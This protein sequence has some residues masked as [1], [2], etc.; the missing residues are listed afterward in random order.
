[1]MGKREVAEVAEKIGAMRAASAL[2]AEIEAK[3]GMGRRIN[4]VGKDGAPTGRTI[5]HGEVLRAAGQIAEYELAV[6][7]GKRPAQVV[8]DVCHTIVEVPSTGPTPK[9]HRACARRIRNARHRS[10]D[11]GKTTNAAGRKTRV[12]RRR[13]K[14]LC[15]ECT[16]VPK[17]A[18]DGRGGLCVGCAERRNARRRAPD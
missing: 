4:V 16:G 3:G 15:V 8:C 6:Q 5:S 1:M 13:G 10:T 12:K 17:P 14:G 7:D 18:A 2:I 9:M 11:K